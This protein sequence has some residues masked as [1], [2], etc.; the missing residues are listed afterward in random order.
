MENKQPAVQ[1]EQALSAAPQFRLRTGLRG[2]ESVEACQKNLKE[3]QDN[4]YKYYNQV[5]ATKSTP[6]NHL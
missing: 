6:C 5:N 2:G 1:Q 4:Y 3:W